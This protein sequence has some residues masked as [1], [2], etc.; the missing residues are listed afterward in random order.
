MLQSLLAICEFAGIFG[1][2]GS[3]F[4]KKSEIFSMKGKY[5]LIEC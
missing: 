2:N 1:K 4:V 5:Y 3:S